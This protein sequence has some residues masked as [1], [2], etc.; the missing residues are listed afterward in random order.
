MSY[1]GSNEPVRIDELM[2][3]AFG[4]VHAAHPNASEFDELMRLAFDDDAPGASASAPAGSSASAPAYTAPTL[5][6]VPAA[7]PATSDVVEH[8][9][10]TP[11]LDPN[12][13]WLRSA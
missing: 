3:L 12:P 4:E 10:C 8:P 9:A 6:A 7:S 1:R 11:T 5:H 2:N 13:V